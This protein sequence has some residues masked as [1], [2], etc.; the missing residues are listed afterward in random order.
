MES[1]LAKLA[2]R[3][4]GLKLEVLRDDGGAAAGGIPAPG[5]S[6]PAPPKASAVESATSSAEDKPAPPAPDA[7]GPDADPAELFKNDPLIQKAL[8]IFEG[9]IRSVE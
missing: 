4:V 1:L 7:A 6:A 8:K 3:P 5:P 9:E 2:G